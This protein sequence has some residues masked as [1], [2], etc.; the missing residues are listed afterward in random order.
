[1]VSTVIAASQ[2]RVSEV[3]VRDYIDAGL[4]AA[5]RTLGGAWDVDTLSLRALERARG[6]GRRW[7][8]ATAW[9]ALD[10]LGRGGTDRLA[11]S[12][13]SRLR[14]VLRSIDVPRL[15]YLAE[16]RGASY[17]LHRLNGAVG[18]LRERVE[19]SG[20]SALDARRRSVFGLTDAAAPVLI[21]YVRS[22]DA[23]EIA[24]A[25]ALE[26]A[27]DGELLFRLAERPDANDA[28]VALDLYAYGDTRESS[29]GRAWLE[30]ALRAV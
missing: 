4:L 16:G 25:F 7:S 18:G 22:A 10:L 3:Q 27:A 23:D 14:A 9:A 2:L 26:P 5:D 13:L 24:A 29:A 20:A 8:E 21:A 17:R 28:V 19:V 30:G 11:G 1:M 12:Q 15:A 6:R